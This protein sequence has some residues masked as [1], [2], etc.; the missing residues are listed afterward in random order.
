MLWCPLPLSRPI[1]PAVQ[2]GGETPILT[3]TY[4]C[5]RRDRVG[6]QLARRTGNRGNTLRRSDYELVDINATYH[7]TRSVEVTGRINNL[8]DKAYVSWADVNYPTELLIGRPRYF[9]IDLHVGL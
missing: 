6:D 1:L 9:G 2:G 4:P 5:R 7:M 8:L 3:G